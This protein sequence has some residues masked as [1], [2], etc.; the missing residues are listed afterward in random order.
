[1]TAR[2]AIERSKEIVEAQE[3]PL[4]LRAFEGASDILSDNPCPRLSKVTTRANLE[5]R[6][7]KA[8]HPANSCW[9]S[10]CDM[11][12]DQNNIDRPVAPPLVGDTYVAAERVTRNGQFDTI[13]WARSLK[14]S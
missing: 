4:E 12:R 13:H 11:K 9:N 14:G 5:R 10:M 2:A 7:K 8:V 6:R 1:M 3:K